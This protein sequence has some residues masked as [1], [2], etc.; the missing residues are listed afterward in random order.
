MAPQNARKLSPVEIVGAVKHEPLIG[1][2]AAAKLLGIPSSNFKRDA[3]PHLLSLP[4][5]GS[6]TSAYFRSEVLAL[7]RHRAQARASRQ[8]GSRTGTPFDRAAAA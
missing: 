4:I 1:V 6:G 8:N 5:E 2:S 7:K 3:A